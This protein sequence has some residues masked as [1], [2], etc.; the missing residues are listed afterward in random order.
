MKGEC[1]FGGRF[2]G[3]GLRVR[4]VQCG[5]GRV[6]AGVAVGDHRRRDDGAR[7]VADH[8]PDAGAGL[9]LADGEVGGGI[10]GQ[11]ATGRRSNDLQNLHGSSS[12][13]VRRGCIESLPV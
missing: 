9:R 12:N 8:V 2:G 4:V 10:D 6:D 11:Q 13:S 1:R 3:G 5:L 7:G